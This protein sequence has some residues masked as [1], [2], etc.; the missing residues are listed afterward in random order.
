MKNFNS[1]I[2]C[3]ILL[4]CF[5]GCKKF[6]ELDPPTTLLVTGNVFEKDETA[7][8]AL[9]GL[10]ARMVELN[11][12]PFRLALYTGLS[13]DEFKSNYDVLRPIYQN[14]LQA[15][16]L[17]TSEI[18][19]VCYNYIFQANAIYEGCQKSKTL[20]PT[21]KQQLMAEALFI[22]AFW[23]FYLLNLYGDI[24][25]L[26]TAD[27]TKTATIDR[28]PV[29]KVYEQIIQDLINAKTTLND[30]YVNASS[31][32]TTKD[33]VRP[34]KAVV[35]A[36]LARVYLYDHKYV[37]AEAQASVVIGQTGVFS[38]VGLDEVF[39]SNSN[40]AIW[41]LSKPSPANSI[42]TYEGT[43]FVLKGV[44][45]TNLQQSTTLTTQLLS[46]FDE[47]DKRKTSWVAKF[48]DASVTPNIDYFYTNKYKV[49]NS[50]EIVERSTVFRLAE[51]FLIRAEARA[52]Q[53]N[54]TG[55]V[56]DVDVIRNRAGI[57]L[58]SLTNPGISQTD[59]LTLILK[60]R[61]RELFGE[62]GH[63]WLDLKRTG[64]VDAIMTVAAPVKASSWNTARQL[65]PIP[66]NEIGKDPNL[67]QNPSYN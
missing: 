40:E 27:Y 24:P 1:Y 37:D 15:S 57:P 30:N 64:T 26:T 7:N 12:M 3:A 47:M 63:R 45:Q 62:W 60:E 52:H 33:R 67:V 5:I 53:N 16:N 31:I 50:D 55:A 11:M 65:W 48:T 39:L 36:F 32:A 10:Y 17:E 54:L 59:L 14:A 6:V 21:V 42:N 35:A 20:S 51:Q 34:N 9:G 61:Q 23:H 44:P 38:I 18:W 22:R 13:A 49:D 56:A 41:Q 43:Y 28:T 25:L 19:S 8:A 58:I 4:F 46:S 2:L 66:Q 29:S